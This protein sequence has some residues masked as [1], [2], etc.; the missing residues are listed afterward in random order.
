MSGDSTCA[1]VPRESMELLKKETETCVSVDERIRSD[2][3]VYDF[4]E[5]TKCSSYR[6]ISLPMRSDG[7]TCESTSPVLHCNY[8]CSA[9]YTIQKPI[10][11]KCS[12]SN[13]KTLRIYLNVPS[14]CV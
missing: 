2:L 6:T 4:S 1:D 13:A 3:P 12:G 8:G 7:L 11:F 10:D 5:H 9:S 14:S